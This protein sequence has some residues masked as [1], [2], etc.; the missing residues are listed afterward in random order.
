VETLR[1]PDQ[2]FSRKTGGGDPVGAGMVE[3]FNPESPES[4]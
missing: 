1:G 2:T 3:K 4:G